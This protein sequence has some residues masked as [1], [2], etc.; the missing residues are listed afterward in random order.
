MERPLAFLAILGALSVTPPYL[1]P[2]L[3]LELGKIDS[4]V[5]IVDHVI[6]GSIVFLAAGA[7]FLL[8]RAGR[9]RQDSLL[10]ATALAICMLA[11]VWETSSHVPLVL[12]GGRP[13]S[14][15]GPVILHS[16]LAPVLAVL[17]LWLVLRALAVEPGEGSRTD[18]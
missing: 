8:L 9:L 1:G 5:E 10:L 14:P 7:S 2:A 11:G 12:D 17:S 6:P 3:G 13:E 18:P 16:S 4:I 15:W